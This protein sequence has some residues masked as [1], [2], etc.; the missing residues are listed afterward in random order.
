[1]IEPGRAADAMEVR[2]CWNCGGSYVPQPV[3]LTGATDFPNRTLCK[4]TALPES[5]VGK[6]V[7]DVGGYDGVM[8]GIAL[9]RGA[10]RARVVDNKQFS[11]YEGYPIPSMPPG[12]EFNESDILDFEGHSDVVFCFDVLYHVKSPY[13]LVE[14]LYELTRE[15]LCLSTRIVAGPDDWWRLYRPREQH[16]NDPTV[17]WKPTL[18]SLNKLMEIV[19]FRN[20]VNTYLEK[21]G[22]YEEV[23][24]VVQRGKK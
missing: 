15:T 18:G 22:T 19:G 5:L 11:V 12:V 17:C 23:G 8:A 10:M 24:L 21:P 9:E 4:A 7:L 13:L 2:R 6:S 14:K 1:M 20:G 3:I 16:Q